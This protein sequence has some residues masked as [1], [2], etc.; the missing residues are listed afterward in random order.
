VRR[1]VS[2]RIFDDE[3]EM[4]GR[5]KPR[6]FA[7]IKMI[8]DAAKPKEPRLTLDQ[9]ERMSDKEWDEY[10]QRRMEEKFAYGATKESRR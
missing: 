8:A 7:K 6:L 2:V 4:P 9:I 5:L 10:Y 3:A 1:A